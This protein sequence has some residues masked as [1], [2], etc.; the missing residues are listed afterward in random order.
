MVC[1]FLGMGWM[2]NAQDVEGAKKLL[3]E[4][5]ATMSGYDDVSVSFD[6]VLDNK[7]ED[8]KQE[9]SGDLMLKGEMYVVNL[10]GSTQ[11]YDGQNTYT[12]IPENEEVNITPADVDED[13][14]F[15]PS[16]FYSFYD[17]GYSY[18]MARQENTGGKKVQYV[19]L[20]PI[21]SESE[22]ESILV[23]I[24]LD[25]KHIYRIVETGL[26]GTQTTLTA[27]KILTDQN[28]SPS[29]FAFDEKKYTDMN[30]LIN[31]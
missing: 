15:T 8:V 31:R 10:F 16:K 14:T 27:N 30:Y 28:L 22:V 5:S 2:L 7:A 25:T 17:S 12:I 6:Y 13:N 26:N 21:D 1:F 24:D 23:G 4:A 9:L 18:S 19:K 11:I 20:V 3:D 29:V